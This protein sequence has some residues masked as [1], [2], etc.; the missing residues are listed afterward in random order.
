MKV[1]CPTCKAKVEWAPESEFRPFCSERC[2]LIDL[3]AWAEERHVISSPI[4]AATPKQRSQEQL[5]EIEA[6]LA[7][8][9]DQFFR[10]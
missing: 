6:M 5:E 8:N 9:P 7:A 2:K 3:G 10:Q 1:N 4:A